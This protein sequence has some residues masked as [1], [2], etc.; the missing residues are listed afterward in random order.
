M[1]FNEWKPLTE[2]NNDLPQKEETKQA[3][4]QQAEQTDVAPKPEKGTGNP[5]IMRE[6]AKRNRLKR[7]R[8]H[9]EKREAKKPQAD[10]DLEP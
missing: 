8:A 3:P 6:L 9:Q 1:T 5:D 10:L 2:I 7:Q 4:N